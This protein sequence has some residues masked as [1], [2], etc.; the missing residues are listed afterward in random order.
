M[1]QLGKLEDTI[2]AA[3][4]L[5]GAKQ[6]RGEMTADAANRVLLTKLEPMADL[7]NIIGTKREIKETES[8]E[9]GVRTKYLRTVCLSR[10][11]GTI[12]AGICSVKEDFV[13]SQ[14]G[15]SAEGSLQQDIL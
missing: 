8:K 9:Y 4:Q 15:R 1:G 3:C 7:V 5:P 11:S 6:D 12:D 10:F 14:A 2:N 13:T